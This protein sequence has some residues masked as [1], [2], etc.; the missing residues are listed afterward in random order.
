MEIL[1]ESQK[2]MGDAMNSAMVPVRK[3]GD[4]AQRAIL[5]GRNNNNNNNERGDMMSMISN[6]N[7][8]SNSNSG[9]ANSNSDSNSNSSSYIDRFTRSNSTVS[10]VVFLIIA[11]ILFLVFCNLGITLIGY[12]SSFNNQSPYIVHGYLDGSNPVIIAQD[13][14]DT[15]SITILRSNNQNKGIEFTW[16]TWLLLEGNKSKP[17]VQY[18]NIFNKGDSYYDPSNGISTV[19]NGPGLYLSSLVNNE[20]ILHVVMDTVN[21]VEGPAIIDIKNI[22]FKKWFHVSIRLENK[23]IDVYINGTIA[24]RYNMKSVPKQNYYD[25][26]ICQNG[27]FSGKL[28]NLRYYAYAL[29]SLEIN[30]IVFGGPNLKSSSYASEASSANY[31]A[32]LSNSWYTQSK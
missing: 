19:N 28:S 7:P 5:P 21:P 8:L 14:K 9:S 4:S 24:S 27:G 16:C 20:N 18:Q 15:S 31:S 13:P 26:N 17:T 12:F 6:M 23:T 1:K 25:I 32:F 29:S 10:K 2:R 30:S 22:P 3:L 11:L